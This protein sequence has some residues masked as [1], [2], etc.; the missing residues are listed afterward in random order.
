MRAMLSRAIKAARLSRGL[1]RE[2]RED[3]DAVLHALGTV[4]LVGIAIGLGAMGALVGIGDKPIELGGLVDRF[5]GV[6]LAVT[7]MLVGWVLW[8]GVIYFMGALFLD[9]GTG[10]RYILHSLGI[11]YGPGVLL[12]INSFPVVGGPAFAVGSL[13]VLVA[14]VVAVRETQEVD[15]LGAFLS[16]FL[17]WFICFLFLPGFVLRHLLATFP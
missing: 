8:A 9:T 17:G 10:F 5:L 4:V 12:A 11:S 6:W 3:P 16:T 14:A 13:W 15:W 1:H 7:T 2:L